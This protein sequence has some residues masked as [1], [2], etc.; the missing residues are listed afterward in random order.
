MSTDNSPS[1][2]LLEQTFELR[3]TSHEI[4][5]RNG[6]LRF[7]KV[8]FVCLFKVINDSPPFKTKRLY[9]FKN[10]KATQLLIKTGKSDSLER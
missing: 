9:T 4:K 3:M 7:T 1:D 10:N 6:P 2:I 5:Q 8:V